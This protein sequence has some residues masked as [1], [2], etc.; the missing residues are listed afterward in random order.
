MFPSNPGMLQDTTAQGKGDR[1][2]R[3]SDRSWTRTTLEL[4]RCSF[5]FSRLSTEV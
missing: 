1:R 4:G 3:S 5:F 2:K